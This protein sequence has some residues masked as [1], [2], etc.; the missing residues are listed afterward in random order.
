MAGT[1]SSKPR[2]GADFRCEGPAW[3][4]PAK[5]GFPALPR[6]GGPG[7]LLTLASA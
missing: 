4:G 7:Q 5:G 2:Q 1:V 3:P 6:I